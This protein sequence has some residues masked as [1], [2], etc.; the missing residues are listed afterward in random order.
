MAQDDEEEEEDELSANER[1]QLTHL[2]LKAF[3]SP[4]NWSLF[5]GTIK[6]LKNILI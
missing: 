1:D 2:V 6:G 5:V 4:R 3:L